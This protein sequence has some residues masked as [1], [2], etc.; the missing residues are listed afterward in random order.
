MGY[1][2]TEGHVSD[3]I[4]GLIERNIKVNVIIITPPYDRIEEMQQSKLLNFYKIYDTVDP[5]FN[6]SEFEFKL[7]SVLEELNVDFVHLNMWGN[8]SIQ[9]YLV[10]LKMKLRVVETLHTTYLF[11]SKFHK[12]RMTYDLNRF[13]WRSY[14][15][16]MIYY[17][18]QPHFI[19]I[20]KTSAINFKSIYPQS[21]HNTVIY[22]GAFSPEGE[23]R[24]SESN[25]HNILWIG[26][27][28]E[29]KRP[30]F[31]LQIINSLLPEFPD[32]KFT[33]IGD[34]PLYDQVSDEIARVKNFSLFR[35][36]K[37][38]KPFL[39]ENNIMFHTSLYEGIPKN[40]RYA[41]NFAMP[42]V[43]S[44]VGAVSEFIN[45]GNNGFLFDINDHDK[46]RSSLRK[47]LLDFSVM[48]KIG[49]NGKVT[50]SE[51]FD[52]DVMVENVI[53]YYNQEFN[54]NYNTKRQAENYY[55]RI[56]D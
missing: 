29:R 55:S 7:R 39:L 6:N 38:L 2:G 1:G 56:L 27:L 26:S 19:H 11:E 18:V 3:M 54:L 51:L 4:Y 52:M 31:A 41:M 21:K 24:L 15:M 45:D 16:R 46:A 23:K 8:Y 14:K 44:D 48:E 37:D 32:L 20:S 36:V 33:I 35:Q 42:V 49:L 9:T 47:L 34:G 25:H 22:C 17:K 43:T 50:G 53:K 28:I 30:L 5:E 13:F 10:L 12:F 40:I